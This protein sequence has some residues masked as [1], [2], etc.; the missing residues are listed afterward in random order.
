MACLFF[1]LSICLFSC[2]AAIFN[3]Y[4]SF[5]WKKLTLIKQILSFHNSILRFDIVPIFRK[6]LIFQFRNASF[7]LYLWQN[8]NYNVLDYYKK[9]C[10]QIFFELYIIRI[11]HILLWFFYTSRRNSVSIFYSNALNFILLSIK[12]IHYS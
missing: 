3:I 2:L 12:L 4:K 5:S 10:L 8:S 7:F 11:I 1:Y 9:F 6:M